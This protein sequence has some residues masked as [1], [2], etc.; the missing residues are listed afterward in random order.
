LA[1]FLDRIRTSTNQ[2]ALLR[3]AA[4]KLAATASSVAVSDETKPKLDEMITERARWVA[5]SADQPSIRRTLSL[6]ELR[7]VNE[8][9]SAF[10]R[11]M[12]SLREAVIQLASEAFA[13]LI[14]TSNSQLIRTFVE[15]LSSA[16][17]QV[18]LQS[19]VPASVVDVNGTKT[20]ENAKSWVKTN[21]DQAAG[22]AMQ[23][24]NGSF[25]ASKEG[26]EIPARKIGEAPAEWYFEWFSADSK[27]KINVRRIPRIRY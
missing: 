19:V 23:K 3:S 27:G 26:F 6:A 9:L 25:L 20:W 24:W 13:S 1:S 18:A 15:E 14:P 22:D 2:K 5:T 17:S 16:V 11:S 8:E 10:K 21:I 4:N 12:H 7:A